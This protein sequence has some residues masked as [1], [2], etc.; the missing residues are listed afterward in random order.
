M[1]RPIRDALTFALAALL[2]AG[3]A[4]TQE[5]RPQEGQV[6]FRAGSAGA[7]RAGS[8]AA[9]GSAVR[10]VALLV[11][12]YEHAW[13]A[14]WVE[15]GHSTPGMGGGTTGFVTGLAILQAFPVLLLTW[16]AAVGVVAGMTAAGAL[17]AQMDGG[18]LARI[19]LRDRLALLEAAVALQ[20]ERLLRQ[21]VSEGL[22]ARMG[23]R[24]LALPWYPTWG[25]DT[26]ATDPFADARDLGADGIL[27]LAV[28]AFG[29]AMGEDAD[30]FGIFVR[31]RA[32]LIEPVGGGVRFERVLEYGPGR[33]LAGWPRPAAYTVDLLAVDQARVFRHEMRE[34]LL[35]VARVLAEDPA[36]PVG[37]R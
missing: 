2:L 20:P 33:P 28:E 21:S 23:R 25:P 27:D 19:D 9:A 1:G 32:R 3:C 37:P 5:A 24:P 12:A 10:R 15:S 7:Q 36:L 34:V 22:M 18:T 29:L 14:A 35:R 4:S 6:V 8:G 13:Q 16:P 31:V 17:G 11:P 26:P 30:T